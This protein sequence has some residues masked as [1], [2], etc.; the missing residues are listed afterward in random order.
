MP[1]PDDDEPIPERFRPLLADIVRRLAVGDFDGVERD[2]YVRHPST[3]FGLYVRDYPAKLT[4]LPEAAWHPKYAS[5]Q[6]LDDGSGWTF[7]LDLW[8]VEEGRSDLTMEGGLLDGKDGPGVLI[9][10]IHVM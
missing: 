4:D 8:T 10:N 3:D 6:A 1:T 7:L 5:V 2:G 9:H